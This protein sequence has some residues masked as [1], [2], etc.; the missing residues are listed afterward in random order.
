MSVFDKVGA[1][2]CSTHME[3]HLVSL[4]IGKAVTIDTVVV[5]RIV[6]DDGRLIVVLQI[7]LI[8]AHVIPQSIAGRY[9]AIG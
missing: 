1:F 6:I 5:G 4:L 3:Y 8:D 9:E 7:A 2:V